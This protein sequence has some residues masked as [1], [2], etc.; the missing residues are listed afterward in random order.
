MIVFRETKKS[1]TKRLLEIYNYYVSNS[2]ATFHLEEIGLKEMENI[3]FFDDPLYSSYSIIENDNIIG[4]CI[5]SEFK[6]RK[7]YRVTGEITI[8]IDNEYLGKKIGYQAA[9]FIEEKAKERNIH[10]LISI[11][12]AENE[13]SIALFEKL[14]YVKVGHFKQVGKKFNRLLDVIY[15]QKIL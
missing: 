3:L 9:K 8:Y 15:L 2:T 13:R 6:T 4:Y 14:G 7:A 11:I 12:C 5:L 1:D 10:S